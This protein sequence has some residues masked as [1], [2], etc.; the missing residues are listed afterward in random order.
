MFLIAYAYFLIFFEMTK[1]NVIAQISTI[2]VMFVSLCSTCM[3]VVTVSH[4]VWYVPVHHIRCAINDRFFK[5]CM[6]MHV[7]L[8]IKK[9]MSVDFTTDMLYIVAPY[10]MSGEYVNNFI[11]C[12]LRKHMPAKRGHSNSTQSWQT[13]IFKFR[14]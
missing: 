7:F 10:I 1:G 6:K 11:I 2:W 9:E 12:H 13:L 3:C 8:P 4:L 14:I 5:R